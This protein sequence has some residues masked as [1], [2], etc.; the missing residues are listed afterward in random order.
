ME[1]YVRESEGRI[2]IG[3]DAVELGFYPRQNGALVSILDKESGYDFRRDAGAAPVLFRLALRRTGQ[4]DL[5]WL[6]STQARSFEWSSSARD[7]GVEL[8]LA[9]AAMASTELAV[10][11]RVVVRSDCALTDWR[12]EIRGVGDG[13]VAHQLVCPVVTG[14]FTPGDPAPGEAIAAPV[15][16]EGYVFR[17]PYPVRDHL[18][19]CAGPGPE[20]PGVGF[21]R[22]G[23]RYPGRIAMQMVAVY[24]DDAG[25]Y[26]A[27]HDAGQHVKEFAIGPM[28]G[29]SQTP[30]LSVSHLPASSPGQDVQI[31]YDTVL[32]VFHGDWYDAADVYKAWATR[33]WWCRKKLW[34]RDI[35]G[36]MHSGFGV[37]QMSNYHIPELKLNHSVRQIA[38]TVNDVGKD[39]ESPLLALIFNWEGGGGWTGPIGFF[40]PREGEDAFRDAM[41][42]LRAAGNHGFVYIT[43]GCWYLKLPYDPPFS[44]WSEFEAE[45]RPHSIK[46]EDGETCINVWRNYGGWESARLCPHTAYTQELTASLLVRCLEL[47]CSVVQIDNFPCGG[48][49]ACYDSTHGHVPGHG[50]WWSQ[51]WAEVLAEARR[52]G[53]ECNPDCAIST[54]GVCENFIPYLDMYDHRAGNMEYFGHYGPGLP[55]GGETIP[56]FNYVYNQ[57]IGSYC[58]AMPE[59]NRP[60]VLYWTR[61]F[62][63]ALVQGVVP[64][65]GWYF[66]EPDAL[67]PIT[68]GFYQKVIR[69]TAHECWPYLMFGEMLRPAPIEVPRVTSSYCK[70]VLDAAT[71]R[72]DPGQRHEVEDSAVLHS[73]WRGR[74]GSIATVFVNVSADA[75]SFDAE[76]TSPGTGAGRF[77]IER[78]VDGE[79][80]PWLTDVAL[81]RRARL[82][83]A[84]LSVTVLI[85]RQHVESRR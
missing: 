32:G 21:G 26:V 20:S 13:V 12:A 16:G 72:M 55:M 39:C 38:D 60:E 52:R 85:V 2:C 54:E 66:P 67:N 82:D 49:E 31:S 63:K 36:W 37:F 51:G 40:P 41:A 5:T 4:A 74:D 24:N 44:S 62:G 34:E 17:D 22:V 56:L 58:A 23:G 47:G 9:I 81:P 57:Y 29:V 77:D 75:V 28:G 10:E 78:I 65:G 64:T 11:V 30:V 48:S 71:H 80:E 61:C 3:N 8:R 83:T 69:A 42:R 84:A 53:K 35:P 14:L 25:L 70:F 15:Q 45:A 7:D 43:G 33:Q 68:L 50:P 46:G 27:T 73:A 18:P 76:L 6:D 19:L 79:S 59:C 1:A